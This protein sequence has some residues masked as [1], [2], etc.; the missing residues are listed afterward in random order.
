MAYALQHRGQVT[1]ASGL[2]I[3]AGIWLLI[4]PFVLAFSALGDVTTSNV[5]AGIVVTILA[6]IRF[7]GAFSASSLSWINALIGV[8]V[9][10]SPWVFGLGNVQTVWVNNLV[11]GIIILLLASWSAM[12]SGTTPAQ[13]DGYDT[14]GDRPV[15]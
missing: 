3:L 7:F 13:M 1:T 9:L 8:W 11:I 6:A 2:D 10:I 5:L 14:P 15:L 4:S 12:A